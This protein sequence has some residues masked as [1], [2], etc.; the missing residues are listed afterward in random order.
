MEPLL[1]FPH[2]VVF[3][4]AVMALSMGLIPL[5]LAALWARLFSPRK[6]GP[7][8]SSNYE[9]GLESQGDPG[10]HQSVDYYLFAIV[11]LVFD[12][13]SVFLI[14]FAAA[15]S[16]LSLG[17]LFAMGAFL[18]LLVEGLVWAWWKGLLRWR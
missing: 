13:E 6:P 16:G 9:C 15:Y 1:D 2:H 10:G 3:V 17:A 7:S 4:L 18:L 14:P 12:V 5:G 11:F 8:K